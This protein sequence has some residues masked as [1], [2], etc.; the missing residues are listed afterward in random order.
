MR[1]ILECKKM[2]GT[3]INEWHKIGDKL[4]DYFGICRCQRKL[5]TIVDNL[6]SIREKCLNGYRDFTG[7]EWLI[8]AIMDRNSTA[9]MHGTNCEYPIIMNDDP[10][11]K[12]LDEIK[13]NPNLKDN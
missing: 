4:T 10:F 5:K 9:I 7:A 11:W 12:W 8:L 2:N 1:N 6:L 13:D 3:D